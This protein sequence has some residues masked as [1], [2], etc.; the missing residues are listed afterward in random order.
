M[1]INVGQHSDSDYSGGEDG[2]YCTLN[3][4]TDKSLFKLI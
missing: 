1:E 4:I 2:F 3:D